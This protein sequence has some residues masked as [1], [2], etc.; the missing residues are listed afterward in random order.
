M[1]NGASICLGAALPTSGVHTFICRIDNLAPGGWVGIGFIDNKQINFQVSNYSKAICSCSDQTFYNIQVI[2]KEYFG[3]NGIYTFELNH[4]TGEI[5]IKGNN[6]LN[7][8]ATGHQ[9]K[10]FY[11]YFEF[12]GDHQ[13]TIQSYE[14]SG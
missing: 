13:I 1:F 5:T 6:G 7:L 9:N 8:K 12:N 10:V 4:N 3:S 2:Q 14:V 11:P